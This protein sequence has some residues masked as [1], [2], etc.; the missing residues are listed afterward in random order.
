MSHLSYTQVNTVGQLT[1]RTELD[2]YLLTRL[3]GLAFFIGRN[4]H[5]DP[6]AHRLFQP[7]P[8]N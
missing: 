4:Y 6:T 3:A 2:T 8:A 5:A 7:N 1:A